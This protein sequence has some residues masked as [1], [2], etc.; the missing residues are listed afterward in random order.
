MSDE[1]QDDVGRFAR[2]RPPVRTSSFIRRFWSSIQWRNWPVGILVLVCSAVFVGEV[3]IP[4]PI[5]RWGLSA[6]VLREG[7]YET[8]MTNMVMHGGVVHLVANMA[9]YLA[10]APL[11]CARFGT[12]V[13]GRVSYHVYFLLCGFAGNLLFLALHPSG[14]VPMVGA[15]GAIY[16]LFAA[17]FRLDV[18]SDGLRPHL[19]GPVL[20]GWRWMVIS[21]V[22]VVLMFGGPQILFQILKGNFVSLT[23]PIAWEAHVGG[24]VAG[25]F[26]MD[27]MAKKGWPDDWRGGVV[28]LEQP[29]ESS[30]S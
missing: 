6:A 27:L 5:E 9:A 14:E 11:V 17:A 3:V 26:L 22:I 15:S 12:G 1:P 30:R 2:W 18:K 25:I 24:F 4:L 16:G 29:E 8:L 13:S 10:V 23:V 20:S 28:D 21:N 7:H 19:S